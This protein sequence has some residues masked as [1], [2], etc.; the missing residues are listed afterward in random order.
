LLAPA[1]QSVD[2]ASPQGAPV[3]GLVPVED[4]AEVNRP[5]EAVIVRELRAAFPEVDYIYFRRFEDARSSQPVALVID[6]SSEQLGEA[7]LA[8]LH[9]RLWLRG[10][11]PLVYVGWPTRI[12]LLSLARG[13]DF[14]RDGEEIYH[15]AA[16]IWVA[17]QVAAELEKQDRYSAGRLIDGT[18]WDDPRNASLAKHEK[19]AHHALI[20]A[21]TEVDSELG[22]ETKPVL[23]RLLLL[24]ILIKY[25]E[26]RRV[27]PIGWFTRFSAGAKTFLDVLRTGEPERVQR[28]L[29]ALEHR[30]NGDVF[31][32]RLDGKKLTKTELRA[33]A[34]LVEARTEGRQRYLW[35][36]YSFEHLPVEV[37]SHLYQRFVPSSTAV[38]TPPGLATLLLDQAMPLSQLKGDERVLDPA[39]GSGVF[40]V[41]AFRR[42]ISV[43]RS[44]NGWAAPTVR[45]LKGILRR[46][47]FGV[48]LIDGALDL[49]AFSLSLAICDALRPNVIW[50]ELKFDRLRGSNLQHRDFFATATNEEGADP[51]FDVVIGNPPFESELTEAAKYIEERAAAARGRAL[52]DHQIAYLF[53]EQSLEAARLGGRVCLVQPSGF[54]HNRKVESFRTHLIKAHRIEALLDFISIRGLYDGADTKTVAVL[55]IRQK[56]DANHRIRHLT[57]RRTFATSERL[58][59]ELDHYDRHLV[60]QAVAETDALV[61]RANLLGGGR[62]LGVARRFRSMPTLRHYADARGWSFEEGFIVGSHGEQAP[63]ITGQ[64]FLPTR[65]LTDEGI[66]RTQ[67]G[68][69]TAKRFE[70]PREENNFRAPLLLIREQES[71]PIAFVPTGRLTYQAQIVGI[72]APPRE[73][74]A[75]RQVYERL[76]SRRDLYRFACALLGSRAYA[77]KATSIL[78]KDIEGLPFPEDEASLELSFW[79]EALLEDTFGAM[80]AYVRLGQNADVAKKRASAGDLAAFSEIFTKLVGSV[81]ETIRAGDP[82]HTGNLICQPFFFGAAPDLAWLSRPDAVDVLRELV[83]SQCSGELR[84]VRVVRHYAHNVFLII[85]PDRLRYWL[86]SVAIR[87]ADETIADL[88][89]QGY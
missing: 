54:L 26:D 58:G 27:F 57:F 66:D 32:L 72:A 65:A 50:S 7:Q 45:T 18:F 28:L 2:L 19:A 67:I 11:A 63:H 6:N 15:P 33:F 84:T 61:W 73:K 37:I 87:D 69:V 47:I 82:L 22:G 52:P 20:Q 85:K 60:P 42:L 23:R 17:S 12:D 79:E 88:Y 39:C 51:G 25:L 68:T 1:F 40:L 34:D 78:K 10:V 30:F 75:L 36:Q 74:A 31:A 62:L 71:L 46:S 55:A 24:T 14:W 38:Y 81:Y 4:G 13:P 43:W 9:R 80:A 64:P 29:S 44:Q 8:E 83:F 49:A 76:Q 41:G 89:T 59:F 5:D 48:E 3:D 70:R 35:Q 77:V 56:P 21:I 16:Q 53:L 86:R